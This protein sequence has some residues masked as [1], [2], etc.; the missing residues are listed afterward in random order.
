LRAHIQKALLSAKDL[1]DDACV[2]ALGGLLT[3]DFGEETNASLE[4][5]IGAFNDFRSD[6]AVEILN[7]IQIS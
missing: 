7:G 4:K 2:E 3:Y 1:D 5:A 6:D